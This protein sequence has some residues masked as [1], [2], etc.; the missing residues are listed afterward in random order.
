[1]SPFWA[2]NQVSFTPSRTGASSRSSNRRISIRASA[3]GL[4]VSQVTGVEAI[5]SGGTLRSASACGSDEGG[6]AASGSAR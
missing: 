3:Q 4:A 2:Y 6:T 1:M 5:Q